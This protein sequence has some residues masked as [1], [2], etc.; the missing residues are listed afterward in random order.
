RQARR[1]QAI[2]YSAFRAARYPDLLRRDADRVDE[3]R[4]DGGSMKLRIRQLLVP[5]LLIAVPTLASA[6]S[7]NR[8]AAREIVRK[9]QDAI[10][11]V[12]VTLKLR[13]SMAGRE[14]NSSDDSVDTVG[15]VIGPPGLTG[16]S[17]DARNPGATMNRIIGAPSSG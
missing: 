3:V 14:M 16:L 12:R 15:T 10:V 17:R 11:N 2:V 1:R 9:W 8:A 7:D 13:M 4:R 6:Q 5:A